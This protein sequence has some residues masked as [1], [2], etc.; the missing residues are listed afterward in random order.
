[1]SPS[2][3]EDPD[4]PGLVSSAMEL[5]DSGLEPPLEEI[6]ADRPDLLV[7]V[8]EALDASLR[9]PVLRREHAS[10]DPLT[11]RVLGNRYRLDARMGSGAMGVVYRGEDLELKRPV[12]IKV[13]RSALMDI[14]EAEY[15]FGREAEALAVTKHPSV[16]TVHD[17]GRTVDDDPYIVMELLE[18]CSMVVLLEVGSSKGLANPGAGTAWV[19]EELGV[20]HIAESSYLRSVVRWSADLASA[21]GAAHAAGVYHRDVKPSNMFVRKDGTAVL[22]DFGIA[23]QVSQD[24]ITRDGTA[25]GTPAYMA[26]EALDSRIKVG[27]GLDI[28]G[29]CASLYHMLSLSPPFSGTPSQIL[30][31]VATR[32]PVPLVKA[33]PG[34]PKDLLAIVECGMARRPQDRYASAV[35]LESDL[36][37][38]LAHRPVKARASSAIGRTWRRA[39][40]SSAVRAA[41]LVAV[42][43]CVGIGWTLRSNHQGEVRAERHA[44]LW[45]QLPPSLGITL[46]ENRPLSAAE[47]HADVARLLGEMV[48]NGH[49]PTATYATRAAF[50]LDHGEVAGA[51]ADM[52]RLAGHLGTSYSE[53]LAERYGRLDAN[54]VGVEG[55]DLEGL[56][57]PE[58][59]EDQFLFGYHL[60]RTLKRKEAAEAFADPRLE[61]YFPARELKLQCDPRSGHFL[62]GEALELEALA[63][64]RSA[65]TAN[66]IGTATILVKDFLGALEPLREGLAIAPHSEP[67]S[68]NLG[69]ASWRLG[70]IDT[71]KTAWEQCIAAKPHY[72][73]PYE[74]MVS[75]LID[76]KRLEEC[77]GF[78]DG[79]PLAAFP[80][81]EKTLA[82][83]H[84]ELGA[85]EAEVMFQR[86]D[87]G[88]AKRMAAEALANYEKAAEVGEGRSRL[89]RLF[90][91]SILQDVDDGFFAVAFDLLSEEPLNHRR[92]RT[93]LKRLSKK[94][95]DTQV[96]RVRAYMTDLVEALEA[97]ETTEVS[98]QVPSNKHTK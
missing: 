82:F 53:A 12:A 29:L 31:S 34:L 3:F 32:E 92:L 91:E 59:A 87:I 20:D 27:P 10:S 43:G 69:W 62:Y 88:E 63:G 58:S 38:F 83:L 9:I 68:W 84:A 33:R 18:G 26:P 52:R 8:R 49:D 86:G 97:L 50:R 22:L 6:C 15:R 60:A 75:M 16:V 81:S 40:R 1:M 71:A 17:R 85:A 74:H 36:R 93:A 94:P 19:A 46:Y 47:G 24:T 51:Q 30:T 48:S 39:I 72:A 14:D 56:P 66:L 41:T 95:S 64:R 4:L 5:R 42:L 89:R 35:Q 13:L 23:A 61:D 96:Q 37:A 79:A 55:L 25:L 65:N 45:S 21:L 70:D 57:Q 76:A 54:A 44:E 78:L 73:K 28:Y 80:G 2:S 77:R 11:G 98:V 7:A 90:V 67:L